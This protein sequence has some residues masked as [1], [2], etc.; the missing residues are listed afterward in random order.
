MVRA[1]GIIKQVPQAPYSR[2]RAG[3]G[4]GA[5][6]RD[7]LARHVH[8]GIP[9]TEL[10]R[11]EQPAGISIGLA[12]A[13]LGRSR[14]RADLRE[15]DAR[16]LGGAP[17]RVRDVEGRRLDGL[18]R[19]MLGCPARPVEDEV[20][21][22]AHRPLDA[23]SRDLRVE[24]AAPLGP[25][26]RADGEVVR[27]A[28]HE[29]L[30]VW[31]PADRVDDS[32]ETI[33]DK[34]NPRNASLMMLSAMPADLSESLLSDSHPSDASDDLLV[35]SVGVPRPSAPFA[36]RARS[37]RSSVSGPTCVP[38]EGRC[39][40]LVLLRP[41]VLPREASRAAPVAIDVD[42]SPDWSLAFTPSQAAPTV[43]P[44]ASGPSAIGLVTGRS[45]PGAP[46]YDHYRASESRF[47]RSPRAKLVA[48]D[49]R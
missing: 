18:G 37:N 30:A 29:R 20:V 9:R 24:D 6:V 14:G 2:L 33:S 21:G 44:L 42:A 11:A 39:G 31:A 3:P 12:E 49:I 48:P 36:R 41:G 46:P 35:P 45:Q 38:L 13:A 25:E 7:A 32:T 4:S 28:D 34:I 1:A 15:P 10:T 17:Q 23:L 5:Q 16:R 22:S 43:T 40:V 19:E 26:V 47:R 27:S 8:A